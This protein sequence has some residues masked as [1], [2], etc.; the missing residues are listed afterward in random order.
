MQNYGV[1]KGD[2]IKTFGFAEY[3]NYALCIMNFAF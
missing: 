3:L 1:A 2:K